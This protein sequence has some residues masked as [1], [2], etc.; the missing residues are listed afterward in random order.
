[1][2]ILPPLAHLPN[3]WSWSRSN[4][5]AQN[6]SEVAYKGSRD[7]N[8][9]AI[10]QWLWWLIGRKLEWQQKSWNLNSSSDVGY[11]HCKMWLHPQHHNT[12]PDPG[13]STATT[14]YFNYGFK[15][16][17]ER[18]H[19]FLQML[20]AATILSFHSLSRYPISH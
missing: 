3:G 12:G 2:L 19:L 8:L 16:L 5:G 1:M 6:C 9:G 17:N 15:W 4:P 11:V 7:S 18:R 14:E 20:K 10:S 13:F